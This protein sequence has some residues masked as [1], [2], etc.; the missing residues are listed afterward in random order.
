[1]TSMPRKR[2]RKKKFRL[3]LRWDLRPDVIK[4][5]AAISFVASG[6]LSLISFFARNYL[7]NQKIYDLLTKFFGGSAVIIPIILIFTGLFFVDSIDF[8]HKEPRVLIGMIGLLISISGILAL[9]SDSGGKVGYK[10][11]EMLKNSTSIYGSVLILLAILAAALILI[12]DISLNQTL[13]FL[14]TAFKKLR[15]KKMALPKLRDAEIEI[16]ENL[17]NINKGDTHTTPKPQYQ[18]PSFEVIPSMT[19]PQLVN[20]TTQLRTA[21]TTLSPTAPNLPYSNKVWEYPPLDL[22]TEPTGAPPDAGNVKARAKTIINTL[23]S[24]GVSAEVDN[25]QPGPSVTQYALNTESGTKISKIASLQYDLALALASPTGSVRIEAP[26]PGKSLI[27]VE[28]PNN[29]RVIVNFKTLLTSESMKSMKSKLAIVLGKDV[30]GQTL[31]YNVSKMPHLLVA[32]ATGSGKS[33]FLH[34]TIFSILFRASPQECKFI[35]ID[36]KRVELVHYRGIPHLLTPVITETDKASSAFRWA[37]VE[38]EKRYKLFESAKARNIE[39][40]NEKSGFQALPYIVIVVDELGEIMVADPAAVEKSIIRIA[41]LARATGIHLILSVQRPST[42]VI[43]GLIKAN[44]PCRIAFNVSSQI[45]SRV[46]IDQPG[47]EKLL[48][49]GDM[50]FVP[51]DRPK[52]IRLQGA[53][54]SDVEISNLVSYLKTQGVEPEY[55]EEVFEAATAATKSVS[56]GGQAVDELFDEAVETVQSAGKA[57]AS[58]LQRRLSIGYARAARILDELEKK[59]FVGPAKG[60]KPRDVLIKQENPLKSLDESAPNSHADIPS[61]LPQQDDTISL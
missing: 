24:F 28:V 39:A 15:D 50:L 54:V 21:T 26:I 23:E 59:G 53:Y 42:N 46:I 52:P 1:M 47:A 6:G 38:M 32:G 48:G 10:L 57:S 18:K 5:I 12:S 36:P 14:A 2:G 56:A 7:V 16:S 17:G 60:S 37:V 27:G 3:N 8:K 25:I 13:D 43:T 44:I 4:S 51:P 29:N 9:I 34:S 55:K 19:E 58:L 20:G 33:V 41:Q 30:G 22:L 61:N 35:L 40:Y 49:R 45:D 11:L 31:T